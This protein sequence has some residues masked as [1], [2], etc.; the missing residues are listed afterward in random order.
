MTKNKT[1]NKKCGLHE[2]QKMLFGNFLDINLAKYGHGEKIF[3]HKSTQQ[4]HQLNNNCKH[5]TDYYCDND[6]VGDAQIG[7]LY[8]GEYNNKL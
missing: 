6:N 4:R 2:L 8:L 5:V 7:H 3:I 1:T